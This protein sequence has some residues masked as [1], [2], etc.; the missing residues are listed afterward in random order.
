MTRSKKAKN[1]RK[2]SSKILTLVGTSS[3]IVLFILQLFLANSLSS[4]GREIKRLES[5]KENLLGEQNALNGTLAAL[6]SLDRV[7]A[8]ALKIGMVESGER[9]DYLVPPKVAYH[10]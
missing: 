3:V 6:G 4:K 8:D 7:R 5:E 2:G 10:P 1:Q 9:F